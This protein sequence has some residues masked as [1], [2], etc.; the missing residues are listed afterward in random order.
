MK[1]PITPY[2]ELK[3]SCKQLLAKDPIK[4]CLD[5]MTTSVIPNDDGFYHNAVVDYFKMTD[6]QR[7]ES[8][9][10]GSLRSTSSMFFHCLNF[11][12]LKKIYRFEQ[13]ITEKLIATNIKKVD[14]VFIKSPFPNQSV[15]LELPY[16]ID[17]KIPG[18]N[19]LKRAR[20][21]FVYVGDL[22]AKDYMMV[23]NENLD[24]FS[25]I[26]SNIKRSIKIL[27]LG[28][29]QPN[30]DFE[31]ATL[32]ANLYM[33]DG[34]IFPQL[35]NHIEKNITGPHKN[36]I[37]PILAEMFRFVI[38]SMLYLTNSKVDVIPVVADYK[39]YTHGTNH[40]KTEQKN[41]GLSKLE[42]LVVGR[43]ITLS[44]GFVDA[45]TSSRKSGSH[46]IGCP[47]WIVSGHWRNQPCGPGLSQIIVIWIEPYEK[48][49]GLSTE[50][51]VPFTKVN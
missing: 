42:H 17:I 18:D 10:D 31:D 40:T 3:Q 25:M 16:N 36:V 35:N 6:K 45:L 13:A 29:K 49:K 24:N 26:D 33:H 41:K 51:I 19:G 8:L 38:N 44:R 50:Y 28:E 7:Q 9:I 46:Q 14:S 47:H 15:W 22:D 5:R 11:H 21:V 37:K 43:S 32:Y 34:D 12:P 2:E 4:F 1:F 23:T 20:G 27:A 30:Q 39:R 48:G